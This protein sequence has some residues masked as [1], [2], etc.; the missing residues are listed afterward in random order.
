VT[1]LT[2]NSTS[3]ALPVPSAPQP[4]APDYKDRSTGLLV[5]GILEIGG[6]ALAALMI[7]F[8]LLGVVLSRKASG[9]TMPMGSLFFSIFSYAVAAAVLITLGIGAIQAK[10]W[11]R[12]LNLIISWFWL[13]GGILVTIMLVFLLPSATMAGV[14]TAAQQDA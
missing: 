9:V 1:D 5:F 14:H 11:A 2:P 13:V 4:V 10:R 8:A 6:G 7:P 12:A 3:P